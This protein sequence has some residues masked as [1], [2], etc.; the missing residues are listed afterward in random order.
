MSSYQRKCCTRKTWAYQPAQLRKMAELAKRTS[1]HVAAKQLGVQWSTVRSACAKLGVKPGRARLCNKR[2]IATSL[3]LY[4]QGKSY[5]QIGRVV[6]YNREMV[7][8]WCRAAGIA[9]DGRLKINN[10]RQV[11]AKLGRPVTRELCSTRSV[12][13]T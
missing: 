9:Q 6:G 1:I 8:R 4:R 5:T 3:K 10:R 7:A 13:I 2:A 12:E 11:T